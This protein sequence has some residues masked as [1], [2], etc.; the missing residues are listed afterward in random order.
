MRVRIYAFAITFIK[1]KIYSPHDSLDGQRLLIDFVCIFAF[2]SRICLKLPGGWQYSSVM[3]LVELE[4]IRSVDP[5][6]LSDTQLNKST[7]DTLGEFDSIF[8]TGATGMLGS[9][10]AEYLSLLSV[11]N[12]N[13]IHIFLHC[14]IPTKNVNRIASLAGTQIRTVNETQLIQKLKKYERPLVIHA[15]SPASRNVSIENTE[16]LIQTN[17]ELTLSLLKL[18]KNK[19]GF[20]IYFSSGDVYGPNPPYP[21]NEGM[22]SAFNHLDPN[23]N[24]A[25]AKRCGELITTTF[26]RQNGISFLIP[27]ISHTFGP[28]ISIQD[29]RIFGHVMKSLVEKKSIILNSNGRNVRAFLYNADLANALIIA[30][31]SDGISIFN[32]AGIKA[33]SI[34]EFCQLAIDTINPDLELIVDEKNSNPSP[35]LGGQVDIGLIE[36]IGWKNTT[37]LEEAIAKT[38]K[39]VLWRKTNGYM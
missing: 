12:E 21:T 15:A 14:R 16:A 34:H 35:L 26:C 22:S 28:G 9:Y 10:L 25:E 32:L 20:F 6:V 2:F 37:S 1:F 5:V 18:L 8:L 3:K 33:F 7:Q 29:P 24:Y 17:I 13:K 39:S 38:Y 4:R 27:R 23:F 31:A 19:N 30:M 36:S 11:Q